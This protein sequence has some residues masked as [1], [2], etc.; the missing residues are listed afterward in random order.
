MQNEDYLFV[1]VF[2]KDLSVSQQ[3]KQYVYNKKVRGNQRLSKGMYYSDEEKKKYL[4]SSL[5]RL[6]P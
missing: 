2:N 3:M 1:D 6:L 4:D 5:E